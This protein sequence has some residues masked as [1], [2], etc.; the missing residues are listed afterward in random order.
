MD[1]VNYRLCQLWTVLT[2][3]FS[4]MDCVNHGL[5]WTVPPDC[6]YQGLCLPYNVYNIDCLPW[7]V[8]QGLT[9]NVY[10]RLFTLDCLPWNVSTILCLSMDCLPWTVSTNGLCTNV[11][12][13]MSCVYHVLYLPRTAY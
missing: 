11:D 5:P 1:C 4:T 2:I 3:D 13:I 12:Y 9:W 6:V 8:Y 7:A 10:N